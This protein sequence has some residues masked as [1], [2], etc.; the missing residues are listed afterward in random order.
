[1]TELMLQQIERMT[2]AHPVSPQ[3]LPQQRIRLVRIRHFHAIHL[4][5]NEIIKILRH[6]GRVKLRDDF[7]HSSCFARSWRAG[8]VDAAAGA[9]GDG[10]FEMGVDGAEGFFAAGERGGD[11]G[12]VEA[13]AGDLEGGGGRVAG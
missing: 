10:G 2:G 8:D 7:P 1:M 4:H 3:R 9:V 13:G 6:D 12:D 11:G 5:K